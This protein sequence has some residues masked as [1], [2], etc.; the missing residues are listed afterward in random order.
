MDAGVALVEVL[1]R[2]HPGPHLVR[3]VGEDDERGVA[4][5]LGFP[6]PLRAQH[7]VGGRALDVE[8]D[9]G[10]HDRRRRSA[11]PCLGAQHLFEAE[12]RVERLARA[13][14]RR[15]HPEPRDLLPGE[16]VLLGRQHA[17]RPEPVED[18][19]SP[20]DRSSH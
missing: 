16:L 1:G 15:G 7:R 20:G 17:R 4:G 14:A 9:R 2:P 10:A 6:L 12:D 13:L 18:R 19:L 5:A 8:V 3:A 11:P